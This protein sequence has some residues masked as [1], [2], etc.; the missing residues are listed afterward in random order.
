MREKQVFAVF[1]SNKPAQFPHCQAE[2]KN[3]SEI[4]PPDRGQLRQEHSPSN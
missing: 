2:E 3:L 4:L 1:L